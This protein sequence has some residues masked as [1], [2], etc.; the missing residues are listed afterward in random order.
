VSWIIHGAVSRV[1]MTRDYRRSPQVK[2]H[3]EEQAER[4]LEEGLN[5][6]DLRAL[7]GADPR[8]LVLEELLW[9]RTTVSQGWLPEKMRGF[10]AG[11]RTAQE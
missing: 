8:K 9:K 11:I 5:E 1:G 2:S 4:W 10:L 3:G 7:K 6:K